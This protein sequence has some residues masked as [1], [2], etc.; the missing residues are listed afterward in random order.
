MHKMCTNCVKNVHIFISFCAQ[1]FQ[2]SGD[3][4]FDAAICVDL[5]FTDRLL[6]HAKKGVPL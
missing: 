2:H 6:S 3:V 4:G 5:V 1:N